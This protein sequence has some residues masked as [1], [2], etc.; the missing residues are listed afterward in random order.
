MQPEPRAPP[1][2]VDLSPWAM[3]KGMQKPNPSDQDQVLKCN[4]V[5]KDCKW[6]N[7]GKKTPRDALGEGRG[8]EEH[9]HWWGGDGWSFWLGAGQ[10]LPYVS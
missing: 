1:T 9:L 10:H 3:G 2:P 8:W 6:G 4:D 7:A 5:E